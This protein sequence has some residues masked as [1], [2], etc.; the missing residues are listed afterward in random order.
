[1]YET[2]EIDGKKIALV[3]SAQVKTRKKGH[4]RAVLTVTAFDPEGKRIHRSKQLR[5]DAEKETVVDDKEAAAA[6]SRPYRRPWDRE[7][8][9][10][11]VG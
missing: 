3:H 1:M 4:G 7:L 8:K 2:F 11:G 10:L 6:L 9:A 5:W